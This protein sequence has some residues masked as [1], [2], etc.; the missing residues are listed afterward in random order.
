MDNSAIHP[1][2]YKLI[3]AIS[4]KLNLPIEE[5]VGNKEILQTVS[6]QDF[7]SEIAGIETISFILTELEKPNV[8]PR[9]IAKIFEFRKDLKTIADLNVGDVIPGIISNITGF[10]AFVD[11]GIKENGL[12]H[13]SE[14]ADAYVADPNEIVS[15]NQTLE[16]K[17]KSINLDRRRIALT[18]KG[19]S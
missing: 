15:M 4:R 8:D 12:I 6:A 14:M 3:E 2:S 5:L 10:G 11:I 19:V 18:L 13:I 16:A 17:V 9:K 7:V 1:E